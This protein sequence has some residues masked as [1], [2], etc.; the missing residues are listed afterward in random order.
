MLITVGGVIGT[1]APGPLPLPSPS[2]VPVPLPSPVPAPSPSPVPPPLPL[3]SPCVSVPSS[4]AAVSETDVFVVSSVFFLSALSCGSSVKG[5][6]PQNSL[7][8]CGTVPDSNRIPHDCFPY[9]ILCDSC[10]QDIK[11]KFLMLKPI[12]FKNTHFY[13]IT[14]P[15]FLQYMT[16]TSIT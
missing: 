7:Y 14:M 11:V 1:P 15:Y 2:P 4:S 10:M 16:N 6:Q 5:L 3:S 13:D 8:S 9:I 12:C